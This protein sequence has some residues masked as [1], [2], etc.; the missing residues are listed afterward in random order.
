MLASE[1]ITEVRKE[2]VEPS[3]AFW[4]DAEF[5]AWINRAE[6]DFNDKTRILEDRDYLN[7]T[8]GQM[9]YPIPDRAISIR[10]IFYNDPTNSTPQW[11]RLAPK[12]LEKMGQQNPNFLNTDTTARDNP[13]SYFIWSRTLYLLPNPVSTGS[14]AI[15]IF[16]KCNPTALT[17]TSQ[18]LNL[19]E[20]CKDGIVAYVLWQAYK[21]AGER[22]A[23]GEQ[24]A[25]YEIEV[26]NGRR[27]VKKQSGD[28]R[29]RLDIHSGTPLDY[30]SGGG[31]SFDPLS[32]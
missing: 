14:N 17:L 2:L 15:Q 16:F 30:P 13:N 12:N 31:T 32:Y 26:R 23:A 9:D 7:V 10:A 20:I 29:Y 19:P 22:D 6:L 24:R 5:L 11:M 28:Q 8:A 1:I 3:A 27:Y 18:S 4:T 25:L 21:K